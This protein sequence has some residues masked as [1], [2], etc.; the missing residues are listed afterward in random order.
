MKRG[1]EFDLQI[2]MDFW[3]S[4]PENKEQTSRTVE[5]PM[6]V[7]EDAIERLKRYEKI[8]SN[9]TL[10]GNHLWMENMR[11]YGERKIHKKETPWG[12]HDQD[13]Y[14]RMCAF[15]NHVNEDEVCLDDAFVELA[16]QMSRNTTGDSSGLLQYLELQ[17]E[18]FEKLENLGE[19]NNG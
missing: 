2:A 12:V 15:V 8:V 13:T 14:K 10:I 1:P 3:E 6:Y 4:D 5:V 18:I 16:L 17:D 7:V 19:D 9:L 11:K